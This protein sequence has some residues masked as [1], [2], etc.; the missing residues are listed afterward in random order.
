[1]PERGE[2]DRVEQRVIAGEN[3]IGSFAVGDLEQR[4]AVVRSELAA[5]AL[6]Q[7][8]G[9]DRVGAERR[10]DRSRELERAPCARA[11]AGGRRA[12]VAVLEEPCERG[13]LDLH[14]QLQ[15]VLEPAERE[16]RTDDLGVGEVIARDRNQPVGS[17]R[18]G[19]QQRIRL[20]RVGHESP[21]VPARRAAHPGCARVRID[22]HHVMLGGQRA[23]QARAVH[24]GATDDHVTREQAMRDRSL[25]EPARKREQRA[26]D[27]HHGKH[28]R[29][30]DLPVGSERRAPAP[31][32][33][34]DFQ[35]VQPGR[36]VDALEQAE[37]DRKR[38]LPES[39]GAERERH[40]DQRHEQPRPRAVPRPAVRHEGKPCKQPLRRLRSERLGALS[41]PPYVS[42]LHSAK[43]T[44]RPPARE[45]RARRDYPG[46]GAG[47]RLPAT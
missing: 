36:V 25:Y 10:H 32:R 9:G 14:H 2:H 31:V 1:M 41:Y 44:R 5:R 33:R 22:Q 21:L 18:A 16:Q 27:Q 45:R 19:A 30:E 46:N 3:H 24:P 20:H 37:A 28:E 11:I 34:P 23:R 13:V 17:P 47:S 39:P 26:D 15:S 40:H 35:R 4:A 43:A 12:R 38:Q 42:L 6:Q 29:H 7:R 8:V